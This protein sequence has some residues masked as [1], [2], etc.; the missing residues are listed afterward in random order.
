MELSTIGII[1]I[2]L[3][4][5]ALAYFIG[6]KIEKFRRDRYWE[7]QIPNFRK[8]AITK[9][10]AII[11]GQ[12]SEQLAPFLPDFNFSPTE[13]KFLGKPIDFIA[14]KGLDKKEIEEITFV[15]VKSGNSKLTPTEKKL[16]EA[17]QNK[18]VKWEEYRIP[19]NLT[20]KR[21]IYENEDKE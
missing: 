20:K 11:G 13:C 4:G 12:F 21:D 2:F 3:I 15:E 19:E 17:I 9:S 10:R 14:F 6:T 8:E 5:L 7:K 1:A 16:K 18:K